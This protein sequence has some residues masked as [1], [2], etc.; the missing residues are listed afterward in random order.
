MLFQDS[1]RYHSSQQ[2]R[3]ADDLI[4]RVRELQESGVPWGI[5]RGG[6]MPI[7]ILTSNKQGFNWFRVWLI[8]IS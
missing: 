7:F 6:N 4:R 8:R 1:F 3:L 2:A 5:S